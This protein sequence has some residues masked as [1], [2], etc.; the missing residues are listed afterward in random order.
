M[1]TMVAA[2][3]VFKFPVDKVIWKMHNLVACK[4]FY[5][6]ARLLQCQ[7]RYMALIVGRMNF[8]AQLVASP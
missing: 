5:L 6:Q 7:I 2:G 4:K 1:F 3:P 8:L